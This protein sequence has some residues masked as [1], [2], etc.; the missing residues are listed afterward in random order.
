MRRGDIGDEDRSRMHRKVT[1]SMKAC[2]GHF[3]IPCY[4]TITLERSGNTG[5]L[6]V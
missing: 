4:V 2:P 1:R 6:L 5:R 3:K